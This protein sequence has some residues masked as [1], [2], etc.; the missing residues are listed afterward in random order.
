MTPEQM[1]RYEALAIGYYLPQTILTH[2]AQV[3][4]K[5]V[6]ARKKSMPPGTTTLNAIF[7]MAMEVKSKS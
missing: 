5:A 3:I 6:D 1:D 2:N 7:S 4:R